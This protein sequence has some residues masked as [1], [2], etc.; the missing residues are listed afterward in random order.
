MNDDHK[1]PDLLD[2]VSNT[3]CRCGQG[4]AACH[5]CLLDMRMRS[6]PQY[7]YLSAFGDTFTKSA[8]KTMK[9]VITRDYDG[10]NIPDMFVVVYDTSGRDGLTIKVC[11]RCLLVI[12]MR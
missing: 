5:R 7:V 3:C 12:R 9:R 8:P 1:I 10:R 4:I 11:H 2:V 6:Y